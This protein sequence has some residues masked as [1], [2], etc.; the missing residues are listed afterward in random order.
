MCSNPDPMEA[1]IA[2][3]LSIESICPWSPIVSVLLCGSNV[4]HVKYINIRAKL[5]FLQDI[6][7]I[8]KK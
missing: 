4:V 2:A 3:T 1:S 8:I 6:S 5:T 7:E